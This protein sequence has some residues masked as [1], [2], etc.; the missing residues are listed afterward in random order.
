MTP[1]QLKA[2]GISPVNCG[3]P[4]N[5]FVMS[6]RAVGTDDNNHLYEVRLCPTCGSFQA[7]GEQAGKHFDFSFQL[8][9]DEYIQ[10]AGQY[11]KYLNGGREG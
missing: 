2:I 6:S 9:S 3:H 8:V 11:I 7:W 1:A 10:A 4:Q 5:L